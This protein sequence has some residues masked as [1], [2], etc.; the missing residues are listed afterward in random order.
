MPR[1]ASV[2][3]WASSVGAY[4]V[5]IPST[6]RQLGWA[7]FTVSVVE[8]V[9]QGLREI[10][11]WIAFIADFLPGDKRINA[12]RI[13][14]TG[15]PVL[16]VAGLL[17]TTDGTG[18]GIT[19]NPATGDAVNIATLGG[20]SV[21]VRAAGAGNNGSTAQFGVLGGAG[22]TD[23]AGMVVDHDALT[24]QCIGGAEKNPSDLRYQYPSASP[25][26]IEIGV[27]PAIGG[28]QIKE[29]TSATY[30]ASWVGLIPTAMRNTSANANTLHAVRHLPIFGNVEAD[31]AAR[32]RY[33]VVSL[34]G[35]LTGSATTKLAFVRVDR[36]TGTEAT[37]LEIDS[38]TSSDNNGGVAQDLDTDDYWYMMRF[39]HATLGSNTTSATIDADC[40]LTLRKFAVE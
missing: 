16:G 26:V 18:A 21:F 17:L 1:P 40:V 33:S 39:S 6:I 10:G 32:V 28:Y 23:F 8:Q 20:G 14:G 31:A 25:L 4:V 7:P 3:S 34:A 13:T 5:T 38:G 30:G 12:G 11:E 24:Y 2:F 9:N 36:A 29:D 37:L 27:S 22:G 35:T 19:I 15:D